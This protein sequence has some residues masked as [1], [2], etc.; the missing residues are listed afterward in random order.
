MSSSSRFAA[1]KR[2]GAAALCCL[3]V[4]LFSAAAARA[5]CT[6]EQI[7]ACNKKSVH[8]DCVETLVRTPDHIIRHIPNKE[9]ERRKLDDCLKQCGGAAQPSRGR[10]KS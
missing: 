6:P 1:A 2:H 8:S 9:C 3:L 7:R 4:M 5:V 10:G